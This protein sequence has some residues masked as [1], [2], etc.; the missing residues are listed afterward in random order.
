[1]AACPP[2]VLK[3]AE[4]INERGYHFAYYLGEGCTGCGICF[5][6]CPEPGAI[7]VWRKVA[8]PKTKKVLT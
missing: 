6:N 4:D 5:Y 7:T 8:D 3:M 1:V 2:D